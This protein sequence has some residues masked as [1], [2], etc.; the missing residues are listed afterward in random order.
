MVRALSLQLDHAGKKLLNEKKEWLQR[1]RVS[2]RSP[3]PGVG[4]SSAARVSGDVRT[5]C[6]CSAQLEFV[7]RVF[8]PLL[9]TDFL[10]ALSRLM[11]SPQHF[12]LSPPPVSRSCG[13]RCGLEIRVLQLLE[14][15]QPYIN[16]V[17]LNTPAG[18]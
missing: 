9:Q 5:F 12:L 15:Y 6:P 4:G 11:G 1:C 8:L 7:S 3:G 14:E 17:L 2:H 16:H 10:T 18:S 13:V